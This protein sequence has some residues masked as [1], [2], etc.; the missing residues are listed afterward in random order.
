MN[1][2]IEV[3][4]ITLLI[5]ITLY[6]WSLPF[7]ENRMPFGD[8]DSSTHFGLSDYMSINNKAAYYVPYYFKARYGSLSDGK[9]WYPPQYHVDGAIFQL[10]GG[11]R[12]VP[13]YF[14]IA[15]TCCSIVFTSFFLLRKLFGFLP[16]YATSIMLIFSKRDILWYLWGQ[17]GQVV[18]F[19]L[20]PLVVYCWYKY[21]ESFNNNDTKPGYLYF[22]AVFLAVQYFI[23]PQCMAPSVFTSFFYFIFFFIKNKKLPFK[24]KDFAIG[25]TVLL[26]L[27][28]PVIPFTFGPDTIGAANVEGAG[29]YPSEFHTL[30][31]WYGTS[32]KEHGQPEFYHSF[33]EMIGG[34]WVVPIFLFGIVFILLRRDNKDLLLLAML[35]S[36]FLCMHL[37]IFGEAVGA[38]SDRLMEIEAHVIYPLAVIGLLSIPSLIK[39]DKNTKNILKLFLISILLTFFISTMGREAYS[40]LKNGYGG[41]LRL[42]PPQYEASEW[43]RN[44]LPEN[45]LVDHYG[46]LTVSKQKWVQAASHRMLYFEGLEK[47]GRFDHAKDHALFDYTDLMAIGN[48]AEIERLQ[49]LED[50]SMVNSTLLYNK[51][52]IRIYF[53]NASEKDE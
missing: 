24:L 5:L 32:G 3:L 22:A 6:V 30:F 51:N 8:V 27:L 10:I 20:V 1:K 47:G 19:G 52:Y 40:N 14:L 15:A 43:M 35:L 36:L 4:L 16:A 28:L 11:E 7:Q 41:I 13:F 23:H 26:I 17:Y 29:L 33:K 2:K 37:C 45:A 31:R 34:F 49:K 9:I 39:V 21:L 50:T 38:R 42:T 25:F 18:S 12:V 46:I 44:N 48:K 53:L